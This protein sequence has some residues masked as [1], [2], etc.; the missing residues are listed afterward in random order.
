MEKDEKLNWGTV[1]IDFDCDENGNSVRRLE[2]GDADPSCKVETNAKYNTFRNFSHYIVPGDQLIPSGNDNA[3]A[4]VKAE[5]NA[6]TSV[7]VNQGGAESVT[8]DLN[9]FGS[10]DGATVT[11]IITTAPE[12]GEDIETSNALVEGDPVTVGDDGTATLQVPAESVV[13]FQVEGVSGVSD[14]APQFAD[15]ATYQITGNGS[16]LP[17]TANSSGGVE[18]NNLSADTAQRQL[19]TVNTVN[20]EGTNHQEITLTNGEGEVLQEVNGGVQAVKP[21]GD[22]ASNPSMLWIPSTTNGRDFS[23]QPTTSRNGLD[24]IDQASSPGSRIGLYQFNNGAHQRWMLQDTTLEG[25]QPITINADA[26]TAPTLPETATPIYAYGVG[27]NVDVTW[28]TEGADWDTPGTIVLA[29]SGIDGYGRAFDNAELTMEIG[30]ATSSDPTSMTVR[31]GIALDIVQAQAPTT[32]QG[33]VGASENRF[34]MDVT[35]NW[36]GL[37]DSTFADLGVV[38]V[39]GTATATGGSVDATLN[40]IVTDSEDVNIAPDSSPSATFTE[41][42]YNVANTIDGVTTDKAWSNWKSAPSRTEDTLTYEWDTDHE[43]TSAKIFFLKDGTDSWPATITPEYR[44]LEKG[45]WT[46][47]EPVVVAEEK[48]DPAP[49]VDIDLGVQSDAVRFVLTGRADTHIIVAETEVYSPAASASSYSELARLT[50]GGANV[51]GFD[52][53]MLDYEVTYEGTDYPT[54]NAVPLDRDATVEITQATA[55]NPVATVVVTSADGTSTTTYTVAIDLV[56][57]PVLPSVEFVD[58]GEGAVVERGQDVTAIVSDAEEGAAGEFGFHSDPVVLA[59]GAADETGAIEL[60][61]AIPEDAEPGA[62]ALVVT[63]D[64]EELGRVNVTVPSDD[65]GDP[66]TDPTDP[67]EPDPDPTDPSDPDTDPSDPGES[68]GPSDPGAE[69]SDSAPSD[70]ES[71]GLPNTGANAALGVVGLMLVLAGG[72][73]LVLRRAANQ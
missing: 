11:P 4:A 47:L 65:G 49:V 10:F 44:N 29:G 67:S 61:G 9:N 57:P 33:H 8:I 31:Q 34:D 58:L 30:G 23:L 71:G 6:M 52:P 32:V 22:P 21:S 42:G 1:F 54:V 38:S 46:A 55:D 20:G 45:D 2:D 50:V 15:G 13:T 18:I 70:G 12:A 37:D 60:T 48:D 27:E 40:V 66:G 53:E 41:S 56:E 43:L 19:W 16:G 63:L 73:V 39:S 28:D 51:E 17:L 72:A 36:D 62:H 68:G 59:E 3:A 24:I 69:P 25:F 14:E 35:W 7:Y 5:G 64:D 26:G